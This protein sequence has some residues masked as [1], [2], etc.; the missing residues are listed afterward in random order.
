MATCRNN[1]LNGGGGADTL[2]GLAGNDS[3][4]VDNAADKDLEAAGQGTDN[5]NASVSY[6]SRAG[7]SVETLRQATNRQRPPST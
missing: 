2:R 5:V 6:T 3:S 1:I 7:V 4:V